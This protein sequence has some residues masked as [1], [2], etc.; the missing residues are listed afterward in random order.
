MRRTWEEAPDSAQARRIDGPTR[1]GTAKPS[2]KT[3]TP[4]ANVRR[5]IRISEEKRRF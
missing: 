5:E 3:K 1:G 4:G 2:R